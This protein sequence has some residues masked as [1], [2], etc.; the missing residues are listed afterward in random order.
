MTHGFKQLFGNFRHRELIPKSFFAID[1]DE[2]NLLLRIDP[3]SNL[4]RQTLASE[5]F[6]L[7]NR[8]PQTSNV[9]TSGM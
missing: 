4:V 9:A 6:H 1:S 8:T 5:D 7:D 3:R 2:I